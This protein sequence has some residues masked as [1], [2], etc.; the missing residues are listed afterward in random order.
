MIRLFTTLALMAA[1]VWCCSCGG[2]NNSPDPAPPPSRNPA[3]RQA[4]LTSV[5]HII[6]MLQENRSFDHYF[7]MLNEYRKAKGLPQDVDVTPANASQLAYDKSTTFTP[8]HMNSMCVEDMS[9]YWNESH[10]AWNHSDH[11]SPV[12]MMD[13]FAHA[14]GG[15]SRIAGGFDINGQR[16]MGYYT[17]QDLPY[18]YFM[19]TQFAMS[20]RWFSPVMTNTP[21]NRLYSM[22]ATST[23]IVSKPLTKVNVPTI[24]DQLQAAGITWKNYVPDYPNGS[25]LKPFPA[26]AKFVGINIV[27]MN[28]Y[29][30]DLQNGTLPQVAFIDRDSINGLDEHPGP[31]ISVQKGAAYVKTIIDAL[32]N[33]SAWKDSVFFFSFDEF[34]GPYDHVPPVQTVSPDD[35]KPLLGA[36]D[37]CTKGNTSAG[38][39]LDMCDFDI[40]GF[41]MP[42][43][44]VSP[45]AKPHYVDH[46]DID[47]TAI[48][49][50]IERRFNLQPLTKRDA[51][52]PDISTMFDFTG[53]P[54]LNPPQPPDQPTNGP[55]Y[56]NALP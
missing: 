22:A 36:N 52:Q 37:V 48:L 50:F 18:Y 2:A 19:A 14:A 39:P 24:F 13:G 28:Q 9:P 3:P 40:T 27:P 38:G 25:S 4:G 53:A 44:V 17:D 35:I 21:A 7:G 23:G 31:G 33:S 46:Q 43:F 54:N 34:G 32:M 1:L 11:T 20:D 5:N 12:P 16:V 29:F 47:T 55:C 45:F 41:R 49:A 56:T 15:D 51:A 26:Y 42:N 6:F 10:N 8:F 30:T